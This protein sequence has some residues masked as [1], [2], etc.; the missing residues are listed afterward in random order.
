[1]TE[2]LFGT[3][4]RPENRL[5]RHLDDLSGVKHLH[6]RKP[7]DPE[8][9]QPILLTLTTGGSVPYNS[10]RCFFTL[11]GTDPALP[12]AANLDLQP[13]T[14]IWDDPAWSY[15]RTWTAVLPPQPPGTLLRYHLAARRADNA[16][17]V[18]ADNQSVDI[19]GADR[20]S[21]WI[22]DDPPPAWARQAIV[23][24]IFPDRFY[25]GD[26]RAWNKARSLTDF[27]G[28]TLR[29]VIDK[30]DYIQSLGFNTLWLN[31]FFRTDSHH[32][33]NARDYYAVEPRLGTQEDLA[34]LI[35]K[36]HARGLRLILDFVANHWSRE[37]FTFQEALR[38]P[39]SPYRDWYLWKR[40]PD[41]YECYF[42]VRELP[43]INLDFGPARAYLLEVARHWLR[44]GFD[45]YRL[46]FAYG[47]SHGFWVDFRRACREVKPDCWIF[48]EVIHTPAMLLSY[49]GIMD[50]TLDFHLAR[51]LRST[52]AEGEM[53]LAE[54]EATLAAHEKYF[55]AEHL[56]PSFLDNH[57][58]ERFLHLAGNDKARLRL[59]ALVLFTL[60]GP[61]IVYCGTET[62]LSQERPM[63]QN[64]RNIFEECRLPMNWETA[65]AD[66]QAYFRQLAGLR[67]AHPFL[68]NGTRQVVLLDETTHTYAY[69]RSSPDGRAL[70]ALNLDRSPQTLVL[71]ASGLGE[72]PSDQ[73][74]GHPVRVRG[75]RLELDLPPQSGAFL[76]P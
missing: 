29:G 56:R 63:L 10:A 36:A 7:L 55:P 5:A 67:R 72:A 54:F 16:A 8:P 35:E 66:L 61:P 18:F 32:G 13:D 23:Y 17:W 26:G 21:L 58:E 60:S 65:D 15:V 22:D 31:P 3:L 51:L 43:K 6:R 46:D 30:L 52:F 19:N 4:D 24:Q 45:G 75:E 64:G 62:G 25:P 38:D 71:P 50:G 41:D 47:P 14:V 12:S 74:N 59:A 70:V 73:L 1:M 34:E 42:Q 40:W 44:Q 2:N 49:T 9:G 39:K 37:H 57:D 68:Q 11:D 28:G 48:G 20:F 76:V 33:Y 27:Y 53:S 69:L